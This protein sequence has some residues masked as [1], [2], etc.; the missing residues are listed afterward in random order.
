M[1]LVEV[2]GPA[3]ISV[4]ATKEEIALYGRP[5][6]IEMHHTDPFRRIWPKYKSGPDRDPNNQDEKRPGYK[7]VPVIDGASIIEPV[8]EGDNPNKT[9]IINKYF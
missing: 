8:G 2:H 9:E 6:V 7:E 4:F 1:G 3:G 5:G